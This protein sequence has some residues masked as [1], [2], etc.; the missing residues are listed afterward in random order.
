MTPRQAP[1]ATQPRLLLT[2]KL[3]GQPQRRTGASG[4]PF[5]TAKV[6]AAAGDGEGVFVNVIA[7]SADAQAALLALG[8]G[9]SVALA[10]ELTP[11]T[12]TD[13]QGQARPALD[14]VAHAVL[15]AYHVNRRRKAVVEQRE[16]GAL[17]RD[18]SKALPRMRQGKAMKAL[19]RGSEGDAKPFEGA[20][21][22]FFP[23]GAAVLFDDVFLQLI[24]P[25]GADGC[26]APRRLPRTRPAALSA[27]TPRGHIDPSGGTAQLLRVLFS[28]PQR[29]WSHWEILAQL[30]EKK[31]LNWSL[32]YALSMGWIERTGDARS[33]RYLRYRITRL[34][35]RLYE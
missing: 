32:R 7:F 31:S 5:V 14:L 17:M 2:G 10:G 19:R 24:K 16:E 12:W 18:C 34:G 22:D 6:R 29:F 33:A 15:T 23:R 3:F 8:D 20:W 28:K 1:M 11:K 21:A 27:L 9:E 26:G 13:K 30:Q 4:K 35:A 25:Q